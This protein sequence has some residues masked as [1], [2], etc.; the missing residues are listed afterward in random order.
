M[1]PPFV[2]GKASFH[3]DGDNLTFTL[4]QLV[5]G[6]VSE[7]MGLLEQ[8]PTRFADRS[9]ILPVSVGPG[10]RRL[11]TTSSSTCARLI[12]STRV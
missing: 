4:V 11:S 5:D 8:N 10:R 9:Y 3:V 1:H 12:W 6:I 2:K 7:D